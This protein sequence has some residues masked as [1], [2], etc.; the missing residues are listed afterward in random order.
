[1]RLDPGFSILENSHEEII[2][3]V[4]KDSQIHVLFTLGK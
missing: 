3:E 4:H 2:T 1:M